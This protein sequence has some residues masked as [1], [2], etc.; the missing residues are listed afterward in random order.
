MEIPE[1]VEISPAHASPPRT[2]YVSR[3][4]T[5]RAY[6]SRIEARRPCFL[7]ERFPVSIPSFAIHAERA[8]GFC[9]P[10]RQ[11]SSPLGYDFL[12]TAV[13]LTTV[14]LDESELELDFSDEPNFYPRICRFQVSLWTSVSFDLHSRVFVVQE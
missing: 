1:A 10:L 11:L 7:P 5:P 6:L 9:R 8:T 14:L 2:F 3:L 13:L 4:Q 12:H